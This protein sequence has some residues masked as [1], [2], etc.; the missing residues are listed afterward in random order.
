MA[1][2]TDHK[3]ENIEQQ[4]RVFHGY[5]KK[6]PELLPISH[7]QRVH[8]PLLAHDCDLRLAT[9]SIMDIA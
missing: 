2:K 8:L 4:V 5:L 6:G 1:V 9:Q 3:T 7:H